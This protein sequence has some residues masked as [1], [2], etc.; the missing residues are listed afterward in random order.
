MRIPSRFKVTSDS[1]WSKNWPKIA[2]QP[3]DTRFTC[4]VKLTS[5]RVEEYK[6]TI[7]LHEMYIL[8][9]LTFTNSHYTINMGLFAPLSQLLAKNL[10]Q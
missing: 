4:S 6:K 7:P 3:D 8:K 10:L 2:P 9:S 5:Q 1:V